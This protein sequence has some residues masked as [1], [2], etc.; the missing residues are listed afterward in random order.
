MP[1]E[2]KLDKEEDEQPEHG[3]HLIPHTDAKKDLQRKYMQFQML[4]QYLVALTEE[5]ANVERKLTEFA[6]TTAALEKL[7]KI[8]QG[9]EMWSSLGS[10]C[11]ALSEIKDNDKV[12]IGIGASVYMKKPVAEAR[13]IIKSRREELIKAEKEMV[14]EMEALNQQLARL[15]PEISR[16]GQTVQ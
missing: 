12:V 9:E 3:P 6:L 8:K 14:A 2:K 7:D 13:E 5:R 11:L 10:D 15:E 4:R 16:L 1:K